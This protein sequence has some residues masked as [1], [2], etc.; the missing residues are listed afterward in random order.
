MK[1]LDEALIADLHT[2]G[3]HEN[4]VLLVHSSLR[5]LGKFEDSA[6]R[7]IQ[8]LLNVLGENGT[9]LMPALSF[10][11][12]YPKQPYFNV[13]TS[14]ACVGALAE[15]FRTREGTIRSLHP[16]HSVCAIG[17]Y[18]H[19]IINSHELDQ[20][21]CGINSPFY[22][23]PEYQG[24]ILFLGCGMRPNTSMHAIEELSEPPY[25]LAG[26]TEYELTDGQGHVHKMAMRN[27]HFVGWRQRY[28]RLA[29]LLDADVLQTGKV[30]E[31]DCH[32]VEAEP[33][34][35][36]AHAKL[37]REPLFFVDKLAGL[38]G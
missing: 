25:L 4:G 26:V 20:T 11:T 23:L 10:A 33:M 9:L 14:P 13:L 19:E 5:S 17:K 22:K 29:Q 30:L 8:A 34:W 21:P 31:A 6:E 18:A 15:Y 1:N 37:Q 38:R 27:H 12:V 3:I 28:E 35:A 36:V 24:Q 2:L 7:V 16:T 32:L